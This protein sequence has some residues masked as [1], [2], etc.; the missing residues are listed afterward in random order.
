MLSHHSSVKLDRGC[1][2]SC[3]DIAVRFTDPLHEDHLHLPSLQ[4]RTLPPIKKPISTSASKTTSQRLQKATSVSLPTSLPSKQAKQPGLRTAGVHNL[5]NPI[6][7]EDHTN[8]GSKP[9]PP[10]KR[11][12]DSSH[13]TTTLTLPSARP[14]YLQQ[15]Q[16]HPS[17]RT[18]DYEGLII[19]SLAPPYPVAQNVIQSTQSSACDRLPH[20]GSGMALISQPQ[21]FPSSISSSDHTSKMTLGTDGPYSMMTMDT[22]SELLHVPLDMQS[23]SKVADEKRKRNA[24]ASYRF[25]QRRKEK[26]RETTKKFSELEQKIRKL[27]EER[28]Y[29]RDIAARTSGQAPLLPQPSSLGQMRLEFLNAPI[30]QS[31]ARSQHPDRN[32]GSN[33]SAY[34]PPRGSHAF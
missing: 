26:E 6:K 19:A 24:T 13:S 7:G 28:D 1:S 33:I 12:A 29:Y 23:A 31:S 5:L 3:S 25:R 17:P 30:G 2:H 21:P 16:E 18:Q 20:T 4:A 27:E 15:S 22:G 9:R 10:L 32:S 11:A 8:T 14:P 34:A